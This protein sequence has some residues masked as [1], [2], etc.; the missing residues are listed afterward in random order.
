MSSSSHPNNNSPIRKQ[1]AKRMI[2]YYDQLS[3]S[4]YQ[5]RSRSTSK[6]RANRSMSRSRSKEM[7]GSRGS[8]SKSGL[9]E[10]EFYEESEHRRVK[11]HKLK[12]LMV[13]E[14]ERAKTDGALD[15][16]F[17][18]L[19]KLHK[20]YPSFM[21]EQETPE[22]MLEDHH[23]A[24]LKAFLD[25]KV[26]TFDKAPDEDSYESAEEDFIPESP[27]RSQLL[28]E[29]K[30]Y[31]IVVEQPIVA[32]NQ[33]SEKLFDFH[34]R[35]AK[36][37][38]RLQYA[39]GV[40]KKTG[41]KVKYI[42]YAVWVLVRGDPVPALLGTRSGFNS[43]S[44]D[45]LTIT[46]DDKVRV[47]PEK[48]NKY[49]LSDFEGKIKK[50]SADEPECDFIAETDDG[51]RHPIWITLREKK[52]T[53]EKEKAAAAQE[54]KEDKPVEKVQAAPPRPAR[55]RSLKNTNCTLF[56]GKS[57]KRLGR[58]FA[59]LVGKDSITGND[60]QFIKGILLDSSNKVSLVLF[61]RLSSKECIIKTSNGDQSLEDILGQSNV[62]ELGPKAYKV[63][64]KKSDEEKGPWEREVYFFDGQ[65]SLEGLRIFDDEFLKAPCENTID[66]Q[67]K[68]EW[69]ATKKNAEDPDMDE[70]DLYLIHKDGLGRKEAIR[71]ELDNNNDD[72]LKM[73][74]LMEY[75]LILAKGRFED[76]GASERKE[77]DGESDQDH[78]R[79][80]RDSRGYRETRETTETREVNQYSSSKTKKTIELGE[81]RFNIVDKK[82]R[83]IKILIKNDS[84]N[85]GI[86]SSDEEGTEAKVES[87][88]YHL[89][90]ED[91]K[92]LPYARREK[93]VTTVKGEAKTSKSEVKVVETVQIR[94]STISRS[95]DKGEKSAGRAV[96]SRVAA[97]HGL[98]FANEQQFDSFVQFM[99]SLPENVNQNKA[100]A[101]YQEMMSKVMAV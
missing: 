62:K 89:M 31:H 93:Q 12:E 64:L 80:S 28:M 53:I 54:V 90:V 37:I 91:Q 87:G 42:Y 45:T 71:I 14:L 61:K 59:E 60:V 18:T 32:T 69:R 15:P 96:L 73:T 44:N 63:T 16:D 43:D 51:Q 30:L 39:A 25:E 100:V 36:E 17:E 52:E 82:G 50:P 66:Y 72:K 99:E 41:T 21:K 13:T 55:S 2:N 27:T 77:L 29:S 3:S 49:K 1:L 81:L 22:K 58:A 47:K 24:N 79:N 88:Y 57:N 86:D 70:G 101:H 95:S 67:G 84:E 35:K 33:T 68:S 5:D 11:M 9:T 97:H 83:K 56:D 10:S 34:Q 46:E 76:F 4:K 65:I 78:N 85:E 94:Q 20:G 19:E 92:V 38:R 40:G 23:H 7:G 98:T 75:I 48:S 74:K 26:E 6:E 8:I